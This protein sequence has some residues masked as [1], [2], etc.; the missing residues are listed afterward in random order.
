MPPV[1]YVRCP[2]NL[3]VVLLRS[4]RFW[5]KTVRRALGRRV[6]DWLYRALSPIFLLCF[7]ISLTFHYWGFSL[8]SI[9][10]MQGF[11]VGAVSFWCSV[12]RC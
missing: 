11:S 10:S 12:V 6:F 8:L 9:R 3:T 7:S 1:P 4:V 2:K 5:Q